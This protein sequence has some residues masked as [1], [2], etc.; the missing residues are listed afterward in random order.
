M[1]HRDEEKD[2]W[3]I[4]ESVIVAYPGFWHF[5]GASELPSE[6]RRLQAISREV[7][8]RPTLK[9]HFVCHA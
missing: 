7:L 4:V 1:I 8:G 2:S 5:L 3:Y 6:V 9:E